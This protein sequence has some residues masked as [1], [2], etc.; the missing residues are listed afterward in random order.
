M[1]FFDYFSVCCLIIMAV[2]LT[3]S[4]KQG[5]IGGIFGWICSMVF[6]VLFWATTKKYEELKGEK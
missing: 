4:I 1:K 6:Y 5:E 3:I 2:D